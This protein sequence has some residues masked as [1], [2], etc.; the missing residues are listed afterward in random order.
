[1]PRIR[2]REGFTLA[3]RGKDAQ[4]ATSLN[5][6]LA[7]VPEKTGGNSAILVGEELQP[8]PSHRLLNETLRYRGVVRLA[9]P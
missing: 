4:S 8:A 3:M 9:V 6:D 7:S 1:M 5:E 2:S